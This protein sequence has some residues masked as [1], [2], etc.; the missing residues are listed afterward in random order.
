[1]TYDLTERFSV[2]GG[3]RYTDEEKWNTFAH[4]GQIVVDDPLLFGD[5]RTDWKASLEFAATDDLF[6]YAQTATGFTSDGA[7]PR[8]FTP[9]QLKSIQGEELVS[10]EI[11]A[12]MEFLNDRVRLNAALFTSEYDPRVRTVGGVSQCDAPDDPDPFPYRLAGDVCP[13]GTALAGQNG[14]AW[15]YYDNL[16]GK[17][18]G[19]ELEVTATPIDNLLISY[20]A[21]TNEYRNDDNDPASPNFIHPDYL[22]QPEWNMSLGIQYGVQLAGGGRIVPRLDAF[23]QSKEHLGPSSQVNVCP[24]Q[25][26][27]GYTI[28]NGRVTYEPPAGDWRISLAST[29]LTDKFYWQTVGA[30]VTAAGGA[31]NNRSG[32]PSP[33]RQWAFTLEKR[34]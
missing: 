19:F 13:P 14:I 2:S 33:P 5:S 11:G 7:T 30:A 17:L 8:I 26:L 28:F 20:S 27:P 3:A 24:G 22:L 6:F 18:E 29:N 21:G 4:I 32:V 9:G 10:Y 1:V 12:K 16:P 15:F 25:C 23:Y 31:P 34:F